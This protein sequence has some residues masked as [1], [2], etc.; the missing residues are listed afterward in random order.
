MSLCSAALVLTLVTPGQV[1]ASAQAE[2]GPRRHAVDVGV[3]A[4]ALISPSASGLTQRPEAGQLERAGLDFLFRLGYAPFAFAGIELEA[5]HVAMDTGTAAETGMFA[6]RGHVI[7]QLPYRWSPFLLVGGGALGLTTT[8]EAM[9]GRIA[10]SV[11]YGV[12]LEFFALADV[13]ARIDARHTMSVLDGVD[14]HFEVLG[15]VAFTLISAD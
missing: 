11:H 7:A 3:S 10:P 13:S 6:L 8:N 9:G 1:G 12:G 2:L 5:G 15:G 4:G 14:H